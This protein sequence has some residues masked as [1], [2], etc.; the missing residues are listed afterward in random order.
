MCSTVVSGT[1]ESEMGT[2]SMAGAAFVA[3]PG[4]DEPTVTGRPDDDLIVTGSSDDST[5]NAIP[6]DGE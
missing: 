5:V 6:D 4:V 2:V 3:I 1:G